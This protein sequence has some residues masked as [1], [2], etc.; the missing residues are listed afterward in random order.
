MIPLGVVMQLV[1]VVSG[2]LGLVVLFYKVGTIFWGSK[3]DEAPCGYTAACSTR[4][5]N[6][7]TVLG[8]TDNDGVPMAY[9]PRS[10]L[11]LQNEASKSQ[12]KAAESLIVVSQT[13]KSLKQQADRIEDK[14]NHLS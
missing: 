1:A 3:K 8:R 2:G 6:V 13:L 10:M 12:Q 14:V 11:D 7:S 4:D 5:D 9:I